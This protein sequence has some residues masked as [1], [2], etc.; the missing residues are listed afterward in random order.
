M[1][2]MIS[3]A[4]AAYKTLSSHTWGTH[5]INPIPTVLV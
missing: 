4:F 1:A 2:A 3:R 5:R